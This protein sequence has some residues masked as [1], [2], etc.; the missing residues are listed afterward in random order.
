M[1]EAVRNMLRSTPE[2][3]RSEPSSC[4]AWNRESSGRPAG[5]V[6]YFHDKK[7]N[8]QAMNHK[9]LANRYEIEEEIGRGG[10]GTVYRARCNLLNRTVA[11]KVLHPHLSKNEIFREHLW[12]EARA[13]AALSHPN[14]I[15]IFDL[16]QEGEDYFLVMEYFPGESLR[17]LLQREGPLPPER[18]ANLMAQ[19][20][21]ALAKAHEQGIIHRD[22]KPHNIL[23]NAAGQVK[24]ADFGL[25]ANI[26]DSSLVDQKGVLIGSAPYLAP[27]R[28]RGE[29]ACFQSDIYSA[30]VVLYELLTGTPPF[31][32]GS[33]KEI[34]DKQLY[35]EPVPVDEINPQV[36]PLL[37][38][39]VQKAIAKDPERRYPTALSLAGALRPFCESGDEAATRI[40]SP[41]G[42]ASRVKPSPSSLFLRALLSRPLFLTGAAFVCLAFLLFLW[43]FRAGTVVP[44]V[45]GLTLADASRQLAAVGL[46]VRLRGQQDGGNPEE[47]RIVDQWPP[48]GSR[49]L[50]GLPVF[51]TVDSSRLV[52]V[53]D[54]RGWPAAEA[55]EELQ[56]AGFRIAGNPPDGVVAATAP[57]PRT[58]HPEGTAVEISV[59][60]VGAPGR[61]TLITVQL[62]Q[63]STVRLEV[64]DGAGR[65]TA[66][67][68]RM[69]AGEYKI[70]VYTYGS[71]VVFL[72]IDGRLVNSISV[73]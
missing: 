36:P 53:P 39:V 27:E 66:Y 18:A 65:R 61:K 12:R 35:E 73:G 62:L 7:G 16:V 10:I 8:G 58:S 37:A 6:I 67:Q 5:Y 45:Q 26:H 50:K 68:E 43:Y 48:A 41:A 21:L 55:V 49:F 70:P 9:L 69:E 29:E 51:L 38:A 23:V 40:L 32:G 33:L 47:G 19:V 11:I 22:I 52:T 60:Q 13:A 44:Q 3:S 54:V 30:G 71:G 34:T 2:L 4:S 24:V 20:C 25:A 59:R 64:Q 1:A 72:Y 56:K 14:I 57:P 28:I 15:S 31:T 63:S 46:S 42:R 17:D